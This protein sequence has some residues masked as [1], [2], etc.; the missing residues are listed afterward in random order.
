MDL[1]L[2][3]GSVAVGRVTD[4]FWSD[5]TWFGVFQAAP[6]ADDAPTLDLHIR[7]FISFYRDWHARLESGLN[8]SATEFDTFS[9][10]LTS[11]Q[12]HAISVDGLIHRINEAPAF[13]GDQGPWR[14]AL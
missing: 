14:P 6:I 10:L 13:V 5:D 11:G 4:P 8:P 2:H 7:A 9:D 3:Y 1:W 12:W